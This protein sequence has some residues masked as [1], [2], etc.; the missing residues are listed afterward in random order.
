MKRFLSCDWGTS[1]FRLR[2]INAENLA[3]V[4]EINSDKGIASTFNFWKESGKKEEER[5]TFY[6]D[7]IS[8]YISAIEK[9]SAS[10]LNNVPLIISGMAS[11]TIGMVSLAYKNLPFLASGNDLEVFTIDRS[12]SFQ[13]KVIIISGV[14]AGDDVMRGEE[15]KLAGC[16]L[17][18]HDENERLFI[19]PGTHPKHVLVKNGKAI[20]FKT[21]MTGEFFDLLTTKSIL[22]VSVKKSNNF[23]GENSLQSFKKGVNDSKNSNL[24]HNCFLVRTN[25]LFKK[26]SPEENYFYLSGLLI[27]AEMND[28]ANN[29]NF[30]TIV[31]NLVLN[32][33]YATAISLLNLSKEDILPES[34]NADEALIKGQAVMYRRFF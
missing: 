1:N 19:F 5:L 22:S 13:H 8:A 33:P 14:R 32:A 7:I 2:L 4:E 20:A 15:T 26:Y 34:L 12:D 6:L 23:T 16:I 29:F 9:K 24:L 10:D 27:G 21:Y 18:T 11:S 30:I 25:D 31:G 28:L 3:I 17:A